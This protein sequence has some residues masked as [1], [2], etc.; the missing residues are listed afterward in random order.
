MIFIL[1]ATEF[2][3]PFENKMAASLPNG[4]LQVV[5]SF[6]TTG[7][8][9]GALTEV[10]GRISDMLQRLQADIRDVT[11]SVVA[12]GDYDDIYVTK[13]VDFTNDLPCLVDFVTTVGSTHGGDEP[14]AYEVMLR[15]VRR[16]LK[17]TSG[18]Q[19]VLVVIGDSYPHPPSYPQ[20]KENIDWRK[21][22]KLLAEMV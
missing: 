15:L 22:T 10:R 8:M 14:E 9:S 11:T 7:S 19:R 12:H 2:T 4:P 1:I 5:F 20:N 17:W 6:D 3:I 18:S 13:H 21:E 16:D